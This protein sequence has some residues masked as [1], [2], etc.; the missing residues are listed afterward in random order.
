MEGTELKASADGSAWAAVEPAPDVPGTVGVATRVQPAA[1]SGQALIFMSYRTNTGPQEQIALHSDDLETWKV[2]QPFSVPPDV[3]PVFLTDPRIRQWGDVFHLAAEHAFH[4]P[5]RA[6]WRVNYLLHTKDFEVFNAT[7]TGTQDPRAERFTEPYPHTAEGN[8]FGQSIRLELLP[9]DNGNGLPLGLALKRTA[10][11][12]TE[13]I[14]LERSGP[15]RQF[16]TGFANL[17]VYPVATTATTVRVSRDG[18]RTWE[19][20]LKR[21]SGGMAFDSSS[22]GLP[23]VYG[24]FSLAEMG[25][26]IWAATRDNGNGKAA[27]WNHEPGRPEIEEWFVAREV[28]PEASRFFGRVGGHLVMAG[29]RDGE[30][31]IEWT[32]W[33]PGIGITWESHAFPEPMSLIRVRQINGDFFFVGSEFRDGTPFARVKRSPDFR[34]WETMLTR[35]DAGMAFRDIARVNGT[36]V[37]T[38]ARGRSVALPLSVERTGR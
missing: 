3:F 16:L 14:D 18:G 13:R 38:R 6:D 33:T 9:E 7:F 20:V 21:E 37:V 15:S 12:T 11:G 30:T 31:V 24:F 19:A 28:P 5:Q 32:E 8:V 1:G 23:K 10:D 36:W 17:D 29:V 34:N 35:E 25:D 2:I 26:S 27:I 4:S 22:S